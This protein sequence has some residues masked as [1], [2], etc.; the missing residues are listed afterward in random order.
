MQM[1]W[2]LF[3]VACTVA[4]CSSLETKTMPTKTNPALYFEIPVVDMQRAM[5]FYEKVF[6]FD[7][8]SEEI[9]GNQ[10]AMLP[11]AVEGAGISGALAL[12]EI[13]QPS[14]QGTL[15]YLG[16]EHIDET[17]IRAHSAGAKVLYP[18]TR[19]GDYSYVAEIQDSEGHRVGLMQPFK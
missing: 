6:G 13:Y 17:L 8:Y 14:L 18:K 3:I 11:L 9:H 5:V 16:T 15:I 12:G 10:M 19:A 1:K 2:M 4:A 7:F